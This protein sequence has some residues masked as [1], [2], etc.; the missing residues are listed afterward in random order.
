MS[1]EPE[2]TATPASKLNAI[3]LI[4]QELGNFFKQKE[5]AAKQ[6]EQ[7]IANVHAIDG[8]IQGTQHLLAKL[9]QAAATAEAEV[10]KLAG[11]VKTEVEKVATEVEGEVTKGIALVED[12][13]KKL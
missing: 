4:E 1:T 11:E 3:Q 13:A 6:A 5:A 8:A 9:R 7:A 10:K 2:V 12:L